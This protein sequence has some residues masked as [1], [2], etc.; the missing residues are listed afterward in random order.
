MNFS[1]MTAEELYQ[2]GIDNPNT[3]Y[4]SELVDALI[5]TN[6]NH[7]MLKAGRDWSDSLY[8]EEIFDALMKYSEYA[9]YI[10]KLMD[11]NE[12]GGIKEVI[13]K[14]L[15]ENLPQHVLD[16]I[17][18]VDDTLDFFP[19]FTKAIKGEEVPDDVWNDDKSNTEDLHNFLSL[20]QFVIN[21]DVGEF[22]C[23]IGCFWSNDRYNSR[24]LDHLIQSENFDKLWLAGAKWSDERYSDKIKYALLETEDDYR[25]ADAIVSWPKSRYDEKMLDYL[26]E[27]GTVFNL[28]D[29]INSK[30]HKHLLE[31]RTIMLNYENIRGFDFD[32]SKFD[33]GDFTKHV[34]NKLFS[35]KDAEKLYHLG[36]IIDDEDFIPQIGYYLYKLGDE[37]YIEKAIS[38]WGSNRCKYVCKTEVAV[39]Y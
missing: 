37:E 32:E 20:F 30:N 38:E 4:A 1:K 15:A 33:Y 12:R 28:I 9:E 25:I 29:I 18:P 5:A 24:V 39:E 11:R 26:L 3:P 34:V 8:S 2:Y 23:Y 35:L 6:E 22:C 16:Y 21:L 10:G 7:M 17:L 31:E 36:L 27:N 13:I 14:D 19:V